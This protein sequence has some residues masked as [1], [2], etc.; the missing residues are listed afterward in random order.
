MD[1]P[2]SYV[3]HVRVNYFDT[4]RMGVVWHGNYIK[5]FETAREELFRSLGM[6]Y[7]EL[8]KSGVM[9]PIVD[10]AAEYRKSAFYDDVLAIEVTVP[11]PPRARIRVE[12]VVRDGAG[13]VCATGHTT[14]AFIDATTRRPCRPP[15]E[16]R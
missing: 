5:Y 9:M 6:P 13:D 1:Y 11:E 3:A 12:Y 8:E 7:S 2:L 10:L 14:L 16:M 4:D 15:R